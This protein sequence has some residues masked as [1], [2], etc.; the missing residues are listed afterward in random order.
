MIRFF[1]V[2]LYWIPHFLHWIN[3]LGTKIYL[4]KKKKLRLDWTHGTKL[5][6]NWNPILTPN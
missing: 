4:K 6:S 2:Y 3:S 1:M 5:N